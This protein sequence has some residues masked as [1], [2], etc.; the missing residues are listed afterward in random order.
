M[1]LVSEKKSVLLRI[2]PDLAAE[3]EL[4]QYNEHRTATE[5]LLQGLAIRL[6]ALQPD[7]LDKVLKKISYQEQRQPGRP[8]R[9]AAAAN[10]SAAPAAPDEPA[11]TDWDLDHA[12]TGS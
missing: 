12:G 5:I 2:P 4:A 8:P 10:G 11:G 1:F 6:R 9:E 3:L 7:S